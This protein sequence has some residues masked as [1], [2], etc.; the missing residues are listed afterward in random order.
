MAQNAINSDGLST[1]TPQGADETV[2]LDDSDSGNQKKSTLQNIADLAINTTQ[3]D[4]AANSN[5]TF[6]LVEATS[7]YHKVTFTSD[8]TL[9][10]T[11]TSGAF[12]SMVLQ[13]VNAGTY[14]VT[15]PTMDWP[16]GSAPTFTSTGTDIIVV[17]QNGDNDVYGAVIGQDMS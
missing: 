7:N 9:A 6:T 3:T 11:F 16:G 10:F 8:C 1:V 17:W 5:T 15:L 4:T 14:T 13:L 12:Q 2:I